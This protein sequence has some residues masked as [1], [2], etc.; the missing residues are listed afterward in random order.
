MRIKVDNRH[1]IEITAPRGLGSGKI[2]RVYRTLLFFRRRL[3]SDWFLD[4]DQAERF[5]RKRAAELSGRESAAIPHSP[6]TQ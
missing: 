4:D 5:A 6:L 1:L 2:V 3:S